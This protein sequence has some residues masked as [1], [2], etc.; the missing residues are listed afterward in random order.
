MHNV[1]VCVEPMRSS[2]TE[3]RAGR[4]LVLQLISPQDESIGCVVI[5]IA[6][7]ILR[8]SMSVGTMRNN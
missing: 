5:Q 3:S 4:D 7:S 6:I 2:A 1:T 8:N